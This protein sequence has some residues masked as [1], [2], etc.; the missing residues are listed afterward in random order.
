MFSDISPEIRTYIMWS[1]I[2]I[3]VYMIMKQNTFIELFDT[4][5]NHMYNQEQENPIAYLHPATEVP[6][7][8][9]AAPTY[10][11]FSATDSER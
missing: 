10:E 7:Y 6:E 2:A 11:H 8:A 3:I 1:C 9:P 5:K 4:P